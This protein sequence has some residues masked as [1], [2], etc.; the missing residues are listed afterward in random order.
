VWGA[1]TRLS[2]EIGLVGE[3]GR[4]FGTPHGFS[5]RTASPPDAAHLLRLG[6]AAVAGLD[7]DGLE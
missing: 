3:R 5:A 2:P 6:S 7:D 4:S 1:N